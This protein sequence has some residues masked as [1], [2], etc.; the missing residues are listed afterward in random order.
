MATPFTIQYP[1]DDHDNWSSTLLPVS[2]NSQLLL[3]SPTSPTGRP[4]DVRY[5]TAPITV[6]ITNRLSGKVVDVSQ[7]ST[8]DG[9]NVDQWTWNG[10]QNQ[11]WSFVDAGVGSGYVNIVNFNSG[12]CLDVSQ[13]ST[14]DGA[15]VDQWT[16]NGGQNQQWQW[17][18]HG[19]YFQLIGRQ[20]GKCLDVSQ[21][22]TADGANLDIWTC[23]GGQN[24]DWTRQ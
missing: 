7:Q 13:Q 22:S 19:S 5:E 14:A 2:N 20:S 3:I 21:N 17:V 6:R 16:C 8:A 4:R 23:N 11:Q 18:A 1:G 24:Q 15:N 9:G 12:K 10:G